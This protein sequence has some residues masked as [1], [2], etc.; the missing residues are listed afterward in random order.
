[1]TTVDIADPWVVA[2]LDV[3]GYRPL[4]VRQ[5]GFTKKGKRRFA[6]RFSPDTATTV[7]LYYARDASALVP[8][9]QFMQ[10][11]QRTLA[12]VQRMQGGG[13]A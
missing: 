12:F 10:A 9:R 8:A 3:H 2:F 11:Y 1:M 6:W 5:D 4:E 7:E 13:G